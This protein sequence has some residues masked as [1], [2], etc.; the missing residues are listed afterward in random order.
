MHQRRVGLV[1]F[2][3]VFVIGFLT[4]SRGMITWDEPENYYVGR[5]YLNILW[6]R[7]L[8][9]LRDPNTLRLP[10][11]LPFRVDTHWER[12]PPFAIT[13]ASFS[14][15]IWSEWLHLTDSVSAH[16]LVV[17]FFAALAVSATYAFGFE[18]TGSVFLASCAAFILAGLPLFFG[19]SH[20]NIKDV[21]QTALFTLSLWL[22]VVALK[23]SARLPYIIA[24]FFWGLA[25]ATKFN[26]VFVPVILGIW[27]IAQGKL[28][29]SQKQFERYSMYVIVGI[30]VLCLFWPWII[31]NP[32]RHLQM[33]AQYIGEVG[34]GLPVLFGG[35]RYAAG[36]DV[37]W[38]Y[39]PSFVA[40]QTPPIILFL[41]I[42][43]TIASILCRS[44]KTVRARS[45]VFVW[46]GV[47]FVRYVVPHMII[48]NGAR[49]VM[50]VLPAVALLAMFG[51]QWLLGMSARWM[52]KRV[53][54]A[55][56]IAVILVTLGYPIFRLHPYE[57][58][59]FNMFA[60]DSKKVSETYDFDYWG[61]SVGELVAKANSVAK[62]KDATVYVEWL[63]FPREYFPNN[64]LAF[65][66]SETE[67]ADFVIIPNS[68]NFFDGAI[69]YWNTHG[70]VI[71][72]VVR[73]GT[74]IG[75]L[76]ATDKNYE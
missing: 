43:G 29:F 55:I 12:Y 3:I 66:Q 57:A 58:Q 72:T 7:S 6:T 73:N 16:H 42:I 69:V 56:C 68:R 60:G 51:I 30:V 61:F 48:Y 17:V 53:A 20:V 4:M 27:H 49:H 1:I 23:Q 47:V 41:A 50:E 24:G 64:R 76:F 2:F 35:V 11:A 39:A 40:L 74:V 28:K 33:I 59:Y 34:R 70:K 21:P 71:S 32:V 26:A 13:L 37:P 75:Y 8:A 62:H 15:L 31:I 22:G 14:S 63:N 54:Q 19:H 46:I 18:L 67:H 52:Q 44:A 5:I 45:I 25:M 38:W 9:P 65:V 36:V 10:Q